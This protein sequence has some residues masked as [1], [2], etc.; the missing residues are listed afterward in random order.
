MENDRGIVLT[1]K[2]GRTLRETCPSAT[3]STTNPKWIDPVA[4]RELR[5]EMPATNRLSH[6]TAQ[7][8]RYSVFK[9]DNTSPVLINNYEKL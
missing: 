3:L 6:G 5:C 8:V 1:G 7:S 4:N 2:N 9:Y